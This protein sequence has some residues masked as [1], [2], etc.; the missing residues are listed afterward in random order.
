MLLAWAGLL[1]ELP[2]LPKSNANEATAAPKC[3]PRRCL[4]ELTQEQREAWP[5]SWGLA[6]GSP[7]GGVKHK[8]EGGSQ[9][10]G[11][12]RR[13][14]CP[15]AGRLCGGVPAV[16][17]CHPRADPGEALPMR[18]TPFAVLEVLREDGEPAVKAALK[19]RSQARTWPKCSDGKG[20]TQWL[21]RP[22]HR[23]FDYLFELEDKRRFCKLCA[24]RRG[25]AV[26]QDSLNFDVILGGL[27]LGQRNAMLVHGFQC[28]E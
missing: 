23:D 27:G 25:P 26:R 16:P 15:T 17:G 21:D 24:K 6:P 9:C 18:R 13:F 8:E 14:S 3:R 20:R 11:P 2:A 19:H 28:D 7:I 1:E 4:G 10:D 5:G 22:G 12:T